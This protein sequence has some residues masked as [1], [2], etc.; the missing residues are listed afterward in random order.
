MLTGTTLIAGVACPATLPEGP[1][2]GLPIQCGFG[3][4]GGRLVV[5]RAGAFADLRGPRT[6]ASEIAGHR[7][8]FRVEANE[9]RAALAAF[10]IDQDDE[11]A[12]P[13][14]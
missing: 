2:G 10:A 3:F 14:A 13:D 12:G 9:A 6:R 8:K 1:A 4:A 5:D 11:R 7:F